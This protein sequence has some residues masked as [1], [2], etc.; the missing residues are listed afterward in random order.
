MSNIVN[1]EKMMENFEANQ[2]SKKS[3]QI[4]LI[5]A[6]FFSKWFLSHTHSK[7]R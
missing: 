4:H 7:Q 6:E 3:K 2:I 5:K 1:G